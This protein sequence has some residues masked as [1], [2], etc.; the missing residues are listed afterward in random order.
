M[1]KDIIVND[2][3]LGLL[4]RDI[5]LSDGNRDPK[6]NNIEFKK[7]TKDELSKIKE[8]DITNKGV[9]DISAL[10]YCINLK[11]LA[12]QSPNAKRRDT[13]FAADSASNYEMEKSKIKDFSVIEGLSNLEELSIVFEDGL[14]SLDVSGLKKLY[15]LNLTNNS[16][17]IRY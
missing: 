1:E 6:F 2:T 14:E 8:I 9:S 12:I 13:K 16:N 7:F 17:L 4:L 11:K 3:S 5:L 15:Y 10:K